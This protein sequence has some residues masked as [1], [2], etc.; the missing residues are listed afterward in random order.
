MVGFA[1]RPEL[2]LLDPEIERKKGVVSVST[3]ICVAFKGHV[4]EK[5]GV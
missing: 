2:N 3:S 5:L 4:Q 1:L